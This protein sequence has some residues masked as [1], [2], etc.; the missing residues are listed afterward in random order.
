MTEVATK[1]RFVRRTG[2]PIVADGACKHP[3]E[4]RVAAGAMGAPGRWICGVCGH[5]SWEAD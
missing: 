1:K 2:A 3:E 5:R 4:S